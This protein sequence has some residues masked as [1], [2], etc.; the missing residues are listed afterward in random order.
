[1]TMTMAMAVE[2]KRQR[3]IPLKSCNLNQEFKKRWDSSTFYSQFLK[4][5]SDWSLT[6]LDTLD[7]D[8]SNSLA[9][10]SYTSIFFF[11]SLFLSFFD[12][13]V[14]FGF[15][16]FCGKK[17]FFQKFGSSNFLPLS[18]FSQR[19]HRRI[20]LSHEISAT[21]SVTIFSCKNQ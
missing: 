21:I 11:F 15:L 2:R 13:N 5:W 18:L 9:K 20:S 17:R 4:D 7:Q 19:I 14:I 3:W 6:M 16:Q 1:M 10:K 12:I 8:S